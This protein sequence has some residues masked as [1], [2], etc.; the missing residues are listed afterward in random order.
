MSAALVVLAYDAT[1]YMC[2]E[3]IKK[4]VGVFIDNVE[5]AQQC[6]ARHAET[7]PADTV[8]II[9]LPVGIPPQPTQLFTTNVGV[10]ID[11]PRVGGGT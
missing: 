10:P 8:W 3:P 4:V 5:A 2:R 7:H 9:S 6:Q 1:A 11:G